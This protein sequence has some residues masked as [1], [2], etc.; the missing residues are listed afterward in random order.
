MEASAREGPQAVE[1]RRVVEA[2]PAGKDGAAEEQH[3]GRL[4]AREGWSRSSGAAGSGDGRGRQA[5]KGMATTHTWMS[6][7][8]YM[9][10]W[11]KMVRPEP[12]SI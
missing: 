2:V 5:G 12:R 11:D 3:L 8:T 4:K 6:T 7:F 9:S 10:G 1:G